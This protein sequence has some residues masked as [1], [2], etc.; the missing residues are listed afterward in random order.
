MQLSNIYYTVY[1]CICINLYSVFAVIPCYVVAACTEED[2]LKVV[3]RKH[4]L[5]LRN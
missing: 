3:R 5:S 1:V 4:R 2:K